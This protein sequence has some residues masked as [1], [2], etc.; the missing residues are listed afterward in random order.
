MKKLFAVLP[1]FL[2][3]GSS[4]VQG[5]EK[6]SLNLS[7]SQRS[8]AVRNQFASIF[9]D[10][11]NR[12]ESAEG[13]E[14]KLTG[15]ID[16]N[17]NRSSFD[18]LTAQLTAPAGPR[19]LINE[20][21]PSTVFAA[22]FA[23]A[24]DALKL[25]AL[26]RD[27]AAI[28]FFTDLRPSLVK[29]RDLYAKREADTAEAIRIEAE[30]ARLD[31]ELVE[32]RLMKSFVEDA[33]K[34]KF[35]LLQKNEQNKLE[36]KQ[37]E[38]AELGDIEEEDELDRE[39][40]SPA[41]DGNREANEANEE[42]E[43]RKEGKKEKLEKKKAEKAQKAE[44]AEKEVSRH[45]GFKPKFKKEENSDKKKKIEQLVEKKAIPPV[46]TEKEVSVHGGFK[47]KLKKD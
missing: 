17:L 43:G 12:A 20:I 1:L 6:Q 29:A 33:E 30:N 40:L 2:A 15:F 37:K 11:E 18:A 31:E 4:L 47:S 13:L 5:M 19:D 7:Q 41:E 27:D 28:D 39:S 34:K 26:L 9:F 10:A 8:E 21:A 35:E 42:D 22:Y 23:A 46:S 16:R 36:K 38:F 45:G 32:S 25:F 3:L 14:G 44:K 24:N